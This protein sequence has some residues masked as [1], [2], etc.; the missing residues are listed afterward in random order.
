MVEWEP[1]FEGLEHNSSGQSDIQPEEE[2]GPS[3]AEPAGWEEASQVENVSPMVAEE[4]KDRLPLE[5]SMRHYQYK[6]SFIL[7]SVKSGLMIINQQ[8]AHVRILFDRYMA[9]IENRKN[10]SQRMLFPDMVHFSPS[11]VPVLEEFMDD[12][13]A[14][15]FELS[16][17]GGGTYAINGIPAGIEGLNPEKLVTDMVHT[18]IEKGCKVKEEVQ[19]MLALSLAKAAAIVPGQILTDEE[20]NRLVDDLFA[21]STP[22]YTP[23]G[24]TVLAVLKEED[25]EKMFK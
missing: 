10:A 4:E 17:L 15:G 1:L 14:L 22:N 7:T 3:Y 16:S 21:V 5:N 6:G 18:A 8:R 9:Q 19:S 12:L 11:E 24:K 13:N 2:S 23:D 25:L 20:M